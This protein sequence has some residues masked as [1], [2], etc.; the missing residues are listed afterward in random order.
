[1]NW[2]TDRYP[3]TVCWVAFVAGAVFFWVGHP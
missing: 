1:M 2:L 3:M